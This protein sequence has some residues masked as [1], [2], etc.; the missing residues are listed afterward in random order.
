MGILS[1][2]SARGDTRV[3]WDVDVAET[4]REAE[5]IFRE[6]AARG[7]ASFTVVTGLESARQILDFDPTARRIVQSPPIAGG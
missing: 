1:V 2:L 6:N 7:Y 4:V 3:E 5:R